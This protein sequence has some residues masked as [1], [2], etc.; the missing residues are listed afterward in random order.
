MKFTMNSE[1]FDALLQHNGIRW[2]DVALY[3]YIRDRAEVIGFYDECHKEYDRETKTTSNYKDLYALTASDLQ[4]GTVMCVKGNNE[5]VKKEIS[6]S[7]KR[8]ET[9]G[10]IQRKYIK[11]GDTKQQRIIIPLLAVNKN[12]NVF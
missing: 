3:N 8:L 7:L 6:R 4:L 5:T 1:T 2:F 12:G 9:A 10:A 11:D